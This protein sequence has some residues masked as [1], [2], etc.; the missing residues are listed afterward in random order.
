MDGGLEE[1]TEG[2]R[3]EKGDIVRERWKGRDGKEDIVRER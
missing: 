2:G 3:G 1:G